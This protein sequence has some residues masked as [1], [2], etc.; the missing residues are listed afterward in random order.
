[1]KIGGICRNLFG[2]S[3]WELSEAQA[4]ALVEQDEWVFYVDI[5]HRKGWLELKELPD[6]SKTLSA[7][8][9]IKRLM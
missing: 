9:P 1:M 5:D 3:D 6:G 8:G 7:D 4:I 2:K